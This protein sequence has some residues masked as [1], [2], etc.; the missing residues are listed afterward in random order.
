MNEEIEAP[1]KQRHGCLTTYLIFMIIAN[2]ATAVL[3]VLLS[4]DIQQSY[5]KMPSWGLFAFVFGSL[6]NLTC[7]IALLRWKKWGLWGFSISASLVLVLN[8]MI[9]VSPV[10]ALG[11]VLGIAILFGVLQIGKDKKGWPQLD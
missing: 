8:L 2:S 1:K 7:A 4:D 5:P 10:S 6:F 3:H 11:G 9:G